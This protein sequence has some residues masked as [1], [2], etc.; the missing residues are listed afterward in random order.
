[1]LNKLGKAR[2]I[3]HATNINYRDCF[4]SPAGKKVLEHMKLLWIP[5]KITTNDPHTTAM[6]A[7]AVEIINDIQRRID[8]GVDGK[9]V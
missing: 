4:N 9:S 7:R 3:I 2:D 5:E 1:M 6:N 8:D